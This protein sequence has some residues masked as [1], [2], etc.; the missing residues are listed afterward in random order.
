MMVG[1]S[2]KVWFSD[3]EIIPSSRLEWGTNK[4]MRKRVL[5]DEFFFVEPR[6]NP[7]CY[8]AIIEGADA[9]RIGVGMGEENF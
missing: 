8:E 4:R 7:V 3:F 6:V 1:E 5:E 9:S 2:V